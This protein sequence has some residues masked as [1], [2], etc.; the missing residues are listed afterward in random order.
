M[1]IGTKNGEIEKAPGN[2]DYSLLL[3]FSRNNTQRV[4]LVIFILRTQL[5]EA[6]GGKADEKK[7]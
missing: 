1:L 3:L 5:Q 7:D 6:I 4:M 2:S